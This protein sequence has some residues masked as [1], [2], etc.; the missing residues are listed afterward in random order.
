MSGLKTIKI[1]KTFKS[2]ASIRTWQ[3]L[4]TRKFSVG[5]SL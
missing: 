4:F 5:T 3:V 1:I 2:L